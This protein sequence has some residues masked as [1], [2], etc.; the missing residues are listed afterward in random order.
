MH[1]KDQELKSKKIKNKVK[2]GNVGRCL[3]GRIFIFQSWIFCMLSR[4][5]VPKAR[6]GPP[7]VDKYFLCCLEKKS[8]RED[9]ALPELINALTHIG[10][11]QHLLVIW[12]QYHATLKNKNNNNNNKFNNCKNNKN[13]KDNNNMPCAT[14][15]NLVVTPKMDFVTL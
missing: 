15:K 1:L 6:S 5:E 9:P 4:K 8:Q 3:G 10:R 7:R 2:R 11:K 14:V 13:K 12:G